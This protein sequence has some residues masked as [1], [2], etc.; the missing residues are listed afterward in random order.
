VILARKPA[1]IAEL[2]DPTAWLVACG[3][4][5]ALRQTIRHARHI[6]AGG[7]VDQLTGRFDVERQALAR[8]ELAELLDTLT[9]VE[10]YQPGGGPAMT[11]GSAPRADGAACR[12]DVPAGDGRDRRELDAGQPWAVGG[13]RGAARAGHAMTGQLSLGD[14]PATR[15]AIR[16]E[17]RAAAARHRGLQRAQRASPDP[18]ERAFR[19]RVRTFAERADAP[20]PEVRMRPPRRAQRAGAARPQRRMHHPAGRARLGMSAA[21]RDP[22]EDGPVRNGRR[23][24]VL[25]LLWVLLWAAWVA[26][27]LT[28][29]FTLP[30]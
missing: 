4:R 7:D 15:D 24:T 20:Q 30:I 1:Y 27:W 21:R 9:T 19:D 23:L 5:L 25:A 26:A 18:A 6:D 2:R 10:P 14:A 28:L 8:I 12:P 22:P 13:P 29:A 17:E 16:A 11:D 3:R